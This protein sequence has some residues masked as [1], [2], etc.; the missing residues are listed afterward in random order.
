LLLIHLADPTA[1][2]FGDVKFAAVSGGLIASIAWSA[3]ALVP[4]V[5]LV[6]AAARRLG[7]HRDARPFAP[8][9]MLATT[10]GLI[11]A[12]ALRSTGGFQ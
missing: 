12:T 9:L 5:A 4:L 8:D 3:A 7:G 6:F 1:L 10:V 11:A 2:G